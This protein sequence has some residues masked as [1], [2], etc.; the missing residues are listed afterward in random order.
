MIIFLFKVRKPKVQEEAKA[1][2]SPLWKFWTEAENKVI[3]TKVKKRSMFSSA[4]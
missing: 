4:F 2:V 3:D 1:E